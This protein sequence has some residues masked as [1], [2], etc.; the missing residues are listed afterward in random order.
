MGRASADDELQSLLD[1]DGERYVLDGGYWVKIDVERS[2]KTSRRPHGIKYSLTL[3]NADNERVIGFDNAHLVKPYR[4]KFFC[5]VTTYDH[6]HIKRT[7]SQ[8]EF[9]S[10]A[11]LLED[12]WEAVTSHLSREGSSRK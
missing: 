11:A 10:P 4:K 3:H 2:D 1:L 8:Y 7:T 6:K 5:T 12:F 9:D